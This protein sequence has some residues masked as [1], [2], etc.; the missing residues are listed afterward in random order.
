MTPPPT[1]NDALRAAI[2]ALRTADI[3]DPG[4]DARLLLAH[5]MGIPRDRL[6]LH[7]GDALTDTVATHFS[8]MVTFR[9]SGQK[10][11]LS[12]SS[13]IKL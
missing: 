3:D 11:R 9:S 13:A 12:S 4:R 6:T 7:L 1:A 5:A 2:P 8:T 10:N